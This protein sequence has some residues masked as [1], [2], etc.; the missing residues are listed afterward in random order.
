MAGGIFAGFF[1]LL[2]FQKMADRD[3][4]II[5]ALARV[6][7]AFQVL[8]RN[9]T[10]TSSLSPI[11]IQILVF[12]ISHPHR[13]CSVSTLAREFDLTKA[14]IS[15]SVRSLFE[16]SLIEK[17]ES[18]LDVRS[19]T[20][21]LTEKG[22]QMAMEASDFVHPFQMLVS[23]LP[24]RQKEAMYDGL[25]SMI[26]ELHRMKIIGVQR[27]CYTCNHYEHHRSRHYC[28]LLETILENHKIQLDCEEHSAI[29]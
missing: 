5:V 13:K 6:A 10:K 24:E 17:A 23:N 4:S 7:H 21:T 25:V 16:K 12:L 28:K 29:G 27:M 26:H 2:T 14:T 18:H 8:L 1:L 20:I 11:Q 3:K 22:R 19:Y 15:D 9:E